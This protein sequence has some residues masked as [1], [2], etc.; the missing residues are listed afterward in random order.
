MITTWSTI[1]YR[2]CPSFFI[3][4]WNWNWNIMIHPLEKKNYTHK[5]YFGYTTL[6]HNKI[7]DVEPLFQSFSNYIFS[8]KNSSMN[9]KSVIWANFFLLF[10]W[11]LGILASTLFSVVSFALFLVFLKKSLQKQKKQF[12]ISTCKAE[13]EFVWSVCWT[14]FLYKQ[15]CLVQIFYVNMR[16][17]KLSL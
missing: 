16:I 9:N 12:V 6:K 4:Y 15:T 7:E 17:K 10:W 2:K 1:D 3:K 5:L 13:L 11:C 14:Y 8:R